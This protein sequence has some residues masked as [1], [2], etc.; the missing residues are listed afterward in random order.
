MPPQQVKPLKFRFH[1]Y[2]DHVWVSGFGD[3][4]KTK[5]VQYVLLPF[6]LTNKLHV[7]I[8]DFNHNYDVLGLPVTSRFDYLIQYAQARKS[9]VFQSLTNSD[10]DFEKFCAVCGQFQNVIIIFEEIQEFARS[11]LSMPPHLSNIVRTGRNWK[12]TYVAVTQRPQEVPTSIM[13]NAR[14]RFYFMQD[15]DA[16]SDKA[17]LT[18]AIGSKAEQLASAEKYSYVYKVRDSAAELR[19]PIKPMWLTNPRIV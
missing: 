8:Y 15:F 17:W 19:P 1:P 14:H 6:F 18:G 12:R 7:I 10:K 3:S 4:G 11:K 2:N 13:T 16:P 5:Y 9:I